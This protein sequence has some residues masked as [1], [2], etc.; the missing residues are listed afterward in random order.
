GKWKELKPLVLLYWNT[1]AREFE[2]AELVWENVIFSDIEDDRAINVL[3]KRK[4]WREIPLN[5]TA[6]E[7]LKELRATCDG[8]G[9][10]FPEWTRIRIS[11][12]VSK[13]F[14]E[15]GLPDLT[16]HSLRHT[17]ASMLVRR[18][19]VNPEQLRLLLGHSD[20]RTTM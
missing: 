12:Q 3:G 20:I 7:V 5:E 18:G 14:D 6:Y 11:R 9:R 4:K 10:V 15:I 2:L 16:T 13:M 8:K 19:D 1:G 17:F